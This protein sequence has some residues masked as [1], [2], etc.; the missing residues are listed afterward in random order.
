MSKGSNLFPETPRIRYERNP[1]NQVVCQVRFPPVLRLQ[2]QAPFELQEAIKDRF[3][4]YSEADEGT[5]PPAILAQLIGKQRR[6]QVHR[7]FSEDQRWSASVEANFIA[8]TCG[9]YKAWEEFE[10]LFDLLLVNFDNIYQPSF[11]TRIGLRYQNTIQRE[12]IGSDGDWG[13]YINPTLVGPL[14]DR[15]IEKAILEAGAGLRIALG[16]ESDALHFQ[17]GIAELEGED[18]RCYLLDF[19]Y[20]TDKKTQIEDAKHVIERLHGY[21]GQ[22]FQWAITPQLHEAMGPTESG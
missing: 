3:P 13:E 6:S 22:A 1:L 15:A 7:F 20:Y 11:L 14:R 19:D 10:E 9:D 16:Y 12:W 8:L 18:Q 17:H 2:A 5:E 4:I 21:S